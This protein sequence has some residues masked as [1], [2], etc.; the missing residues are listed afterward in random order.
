MKNKFILVIILLFTCSICKLSNCAELTK[1]AHPILKESTALVN[2]VPVEQRDARY[3][4]FLSAS[5]KLFVKGASGSG[6]ICYH[7]PDSNWAYVI[8]CGHLWDG[9]MTY[10][11]NNQEKVNIITWYHNEKP[12]EEPKVYEGEALFWCNHRGYDA[13]LVRFKPDWTPNY[14]PIAS[15]FEAKNGYVLNSMGCDGGREV[16]RYEVKFKEM[17]SLDL[18]TYQNSP[19]PGRSGGGL[20]T[21]DGKLVGVCWGT[22]DIHS[23]NGIGYF[24]PIVSIRKVFIDNKHEWILKINSDLD[25]IRIYDWDNPGK[26]Y[27][28][29][30]IPTPNFLLF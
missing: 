18:I 26:L 28:K 24:T 29:D 5:V 17:T 27:T 23:G 25:K 21:N 7:D 14:F 6:T 8:S 15:K 19:R 16:A 4:R 20:I 22:S 11:P 12:L 3:I 10:S 2:L 30:Y 13:S 9:N 1:P